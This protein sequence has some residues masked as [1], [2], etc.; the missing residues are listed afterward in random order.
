MKRFLKNKK[1]IFITSLLFLA[2]LLLSKNALAEDFEKESYYKDILKD[3]IKVKELESWEGGFDVV[4]TSTIEEGEIRLKSIKGRNLVVLC[5]SNFS[6]KYPIS[7]SCNKKEVIS[8]DGYISNGLLKKEYASSRTIFVIPE[9]LLSSDEVE[10]TKRLIHAIDR[11]DKFADKFYE[12]SA[13][14]IEE[15]KGEDKVPIKEVF[16]KQVKELFKTTAFEFFRISLFMVIASVTFHPILKGLYSNGEDPKLSNLINSLKTRKKLSRGRK[17]F[18]FI[19]LGF[20]VIYL[21][22][23]IIISIKDGYPANIGYISSYIEDGFI[24]SELIKLFRLKNYTR[25]GVSFYSYF[26]ILMFSIFA[27][28]PFVAKLKNSFSRTLRRHLEE[29]FVKFSI[30]I[31][32]V[33]MLISVM[34]FGVSKSYQYIIFSCVLIFLIFTTN[35][36]TFSFNFSY[37]KGEKAIFILLFF[38]ITFSG[39]VIKYRSFSPKVPVYKKES[40]I[41]VPDKT[42]VLPYLKDIKRRTLIN[43]YKFNKD[44]PLFVGMYLV[45]SPTH[46]R[47]ENKNILEFDSSGSYYIQ[48]DKTE[49]VINGMLSN[50]EL[51]DALKSDVPTTLV[52]IDHGTMGV[53]WESFKISVHFSCEK[54]IRKGGN[55]RADYYYVSKDGNVVKESRELDYFTGCNE[56]NVKQV[57]SSVFALSDISSKY[58][59]MKLNGITDLGIDKITVSL[60]GKLLE[61]DY[62]STGDNYSV[63]V[64]KFN[65]GDDIVS[66]YIFEDN[67]NLSFD[68]SLDE[69][70][71]FDI[72]G[73]VNELLQNEILGPE[74][75][76]WTTQRYYPIRDKN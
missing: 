67:Y 71:G 57:Y 43:E 20:L 50:E 70:G 10:S 36:N 15:G 68:V 31:I 35:A 59:F 75:L 66:N 4:V 61:T 26:L 52:R 60:W 23:L 30:P 69:E 5:D 11:S 27:V 14:E 48:N 22:G 2:A 3:K 9:N 63:L 37:S 74:F 1:R 55:M 47:I 45:Y 72:S 62:I 7:F 53:G 29:R 12:D 25:L 64:S 39:T 21:A 42:V 56:K 17:I 46:K 18:L 49:T 41:R 8:T 16:L 24:F 6:S 19:I 58:F 13:F 51:S 34:F 33:S 73:P 32:L 40:L 38:L 44:V 65:E 76:I 28:S 54:Y